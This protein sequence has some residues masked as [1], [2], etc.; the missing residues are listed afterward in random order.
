MIWN[1]EEKQHNNQDKWLL[2]SQILNSPYFS[3]YTHPYNQSIAMENHTIYELTPP[4]AKKKHAISQLYFILK[5][6]V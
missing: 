5:F 1:H 3:I 6:T 4:P 2:T